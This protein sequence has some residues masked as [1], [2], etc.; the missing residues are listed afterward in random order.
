MAGTIGPTERRF[1]AVE[2]MH[3]ARLTDD[4]WMSLDSFIA[5]V[6]AGNIGN[7]N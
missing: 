6:E 1:G 5:D 7:A 2:V 3:L 4:V